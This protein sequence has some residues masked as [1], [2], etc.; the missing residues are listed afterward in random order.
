MKRILIP[1]PSFGSDPSEVAIPSLFLIENGVEV[2]FATPDGKPAVVDQCMLTG[3]KLGILKSSLA[4][5]NDAVTA[6]L[7]IQKHTTFVNPISYQQIQS[8]Q[9][10][11]I[12]LPGGHD[13]SVK[14][15][16]ESELLQQVIV[17]FF[18]A[19]KLVAAV[20]H[21]VVLV[22]RSIDPQTEKSVIHRFK[23]TALLKKQEKLAYQLTRWWL[24][25]YY[26]TYP[27]ITVEDEVTN[28]L[29]KPAQFIQGSLPLFRD[30]KTKL[31]AGFVV[32]DRN[33]IS[34]RWPG[35]IYNLSKAMLEKLNA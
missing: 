6:C 26:L 23:T 35:D 9:F 7:A 25:D 34:A 28:A 2:I 29:E 17:E 10:D 8:E 27:E 30:S 12:Y 13:K 22:A 24:G 11:G 15:F 31:S 33:Y 3:K 1:L 14:P 19:K 4:A 20:C 32:Q 16:L 18:Q 21:G 5:N